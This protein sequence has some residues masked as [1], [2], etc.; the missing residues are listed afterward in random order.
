MK[1]ETT[2]SAN[3]RQ[4]VLERIETDKVCPH[5]RLLFVCRDSAVWLAWL[6]SV[7]VGAVAVAV[8]LYVL[9]RSSS[10]FYEAT[11]DSFVAFLFD[12]VPYAWLLIFTLMVVLAVT[13]LRYTKR[14][15]RYTVVQ[16]MA[17][18]VVLSLAG[19][20]VL[21][22]A[23]L[24]AVIDS[25]LGTGMPMYVSQDKM[26]TALW[27]AP[28]DG[29]LVGRQVET[30][31]APTS[32]I[33]FEDSAGARWTLDVSELSPYDLKLLS[34][35]ESVRIVGTTSNAVENRFHACATFPWKLEN[36]PGGISAQRQAFLE[37]MYAHTERANDRVKLIEA[38]TFAPGVFDPVEMNTCANLAMMKRVEKHLHD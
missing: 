2:K 31:V 26:E 13:N 11:H 27:Q 30:T 32:T 18:S 22:L 36:L 25:R 14:G 19:G 33:I 16:I 37:R 6:L 3:L 8:T 29:R 10:V 4:S 12:V 20:A 17:S 28:A 35:L 21:Q 15:Y 24:G 34:G 1:E 38:A 7:V 5:G 9:A 23:G